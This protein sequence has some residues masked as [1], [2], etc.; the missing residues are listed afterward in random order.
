MMAM[1]FRYE[2]IRGEARVAARKRAGIFRRRFT[3]S[4]ADNP[5]RDK[6]ERALWR[7]AFI[8]ERRRIN[9]PIT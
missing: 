8:N 7:D 6:K 2:V 4:I 3:F 1:M 5:Y 9:K